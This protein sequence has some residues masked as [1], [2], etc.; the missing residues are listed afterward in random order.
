MFRD[1]GSDFLLR[2]F[3]QLITDWLLPFNGFVL[4]SHKGGNLRSNDVT[5]TSGPVSQLAC[6]GLKFQKRGWGGALH[7][8]HGLHCQETLT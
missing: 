1:A 7:D 8:L 5:E 4:W 3:Q 6:L 2:S